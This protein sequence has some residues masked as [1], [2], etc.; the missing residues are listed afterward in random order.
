MRKKTKYRLFGW[1]AGLIGVLLGLALVEASAI[2]WLLIE[3]GHYTAATQ[4]FERTQNSYV[5]D[6]QDSGCRCVDRLYPHPYVG[7]VN[8]GNAPCGLTNVNNVGQLNE[9]F[10]MVKRQDRYTILLAGGSVASQLAQLAPPPAPRYLEEALNRDYVSPNGQPFLVLNGG[11]GAWKEPQPF[12]LFALH[13]QAVDAVI[14]LGGLNEYYSFRHYERERLERP[15]SNFLEV[16][17]LV[18][19]E[20]FGHA[21]ISWVMGRIAGRLAAEPVLGQSH[22]AYLIIR[23]IESLAKGR[24][25]LKSSKHTTLD[26]I[27]AL[28]LEVT[29][30][31]GAR[32]FDTQ[33]ALFRKYRR[34]TE[35]IA[36]D[37]N[38]RTA[39]FLQPCLAWGKPLSPQEKAIS[40]EPDMIALYRR[41]VDGMLQQRELGMAVFDLGDVFADVNET[42]YSDF[43]HFA[44]AADGES[45]GYRLMARRMAADVAKAWGL[46]RKPN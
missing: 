1:V 26:S 43:V 4:L 32:V 46:K 23:G 3:D 12:I 22:A 31:D 13:A 29:A 20:N 30:D 37:W 21:A 9:D 7:F 28:P 17:P 41:I 27:F 10:P 5:R 15:L 24:S 33:L 44:R 14:A 36:R 39:Y 35:A 45:L 38:V 18:A 2:L 40:V 16:N 34:A 42:I 25:G 6:M 8:H 11:G 19:D